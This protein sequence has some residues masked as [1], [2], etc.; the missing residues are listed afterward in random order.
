MAGRYDSAE[1]G[2]P[3]AGG[4]ACGTFGLLCDESPRSCASGRRSSSRAA[5]GVDI[6]SSRAR[7]AAARFGIAR[8]RRVGECSGGRRGGF[9][10]CDRR[11]ARE[12]L[13]PG[14][15]TPL[16][17]TH[18]AL[19]SPLVPVGGSPT[20]HPEQPP[21]PVRAHARASACCPQKR[22]AGNAQV[23][24]ALSNAD[25][26]IKSDAVQWT[27]LSASAPVRGARPCRWPMSH[28]LRQ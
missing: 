23:L 15:Q 10:S 27:D 11:S 13:H 3:R 7:C 19:G 8:L 16:S 1:C 21:V 18:V 6:R 20:E 26:A 25:T 4:S 24:G 2:A 14:E 28:P 5:F 22:H 12:R 9:G 17:L